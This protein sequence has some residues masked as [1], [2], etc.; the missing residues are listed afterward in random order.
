MEVSVNLPADLDLYILKIGLTIVLVI[1]LY[2]FI[3][4]VA[5]R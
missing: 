4:Y 2:R 1:E 5:K 3:R